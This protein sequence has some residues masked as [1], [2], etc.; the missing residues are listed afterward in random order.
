MSIELKVPDLGVDGEV[1]VVE[2]LV[3]KGESINI[4][5]PICVLESDKATMEVP[6]ESAGT[7]AKLLIKVGDKV[8]Q[9]D[10]MMSLSGSSSPEATAAV[11]EDTADSEPGEQPDVA[12]N[13][14]ANASVQFSDESPYP[15]VESILD[16]IYWETDNP[17]KRESE[18][19]LLFEKI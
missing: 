7:V 4:D 8:S 13:E 3:S 17:G 9:G 16:D 14:E 2:I 12:P 1:E 19:T 5:D 11:V 15:P 6:A 18:G 10:L